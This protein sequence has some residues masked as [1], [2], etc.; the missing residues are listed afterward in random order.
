MESLTQE[1]IRKSN[2][3]VAIF[4]DDMFE[5]CKWCH[6]RNCDHSYRSIKHCI[7]MIERRK[8]REHIC[9]ECGLRDNRHLSTCSVV[10]YHP[11]R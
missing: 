8:Q 9:R 11:L 4:F 3:K 2:D 1:I 6:F 10:A 7:K 5:E